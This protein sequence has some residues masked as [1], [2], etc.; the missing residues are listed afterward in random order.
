[1]GKDVIKLAIFNKTVFQPPQLISY[2][3]T[4]YYLQINPSGC[5]LYNEHSLSPLYQLQEPLLLIQGMAASTQQ[6]H[7]V[8]IKAN[9]DLCYTLINGSEKNQT[10]VLA[11]LDVRTTRYRRLLL[12]PLGKT[13]HI[14]YAY[15][16]QAIPDLWRIEHRFWNGKTWRSVNLGEVVHPRKPLYDIVLDRRG[17][18][19]LVM[20]T[21]LGRQ[22]VVLTN[23]FNGSFYLWGNTSQVFQIP[24]EVIDITSIITPDNI[25]HLFWLAKTPS[26]KFELGWAYQANVQDIAGNWLKAPAALQTLNG[27]IKGLGAIEV[28]GS[29]WLLVNAEAETLLFYKGDGWKQVLSN[30]PSHRHLRYI[31]KNSSSYYN[32]YWLEESHDSRTPAYHQHLG[33]NLIS[34]SAQTNRSPNIPPISSPPTFTQVPAYSQTNTYNQSP[35]TYP[36]SAARPLPQ[37]NPPINPQTID[38]SAYNTVQ[39]PV[40]MSISTSPV[41][42]QTPTENILPSTQLQQKPEL[43]GTQIQNPSDQNPSQIPGSLPNNVPDSNPPNQ[44]TIDLPQNEFASQ[45]LIDDSLLFA[46]TDYPDD[47]IPPTQEI[48]SITPPIFLP[49][50]I[51]QPVFAAQPSEESILEDNTDSSALPDSLPVFASA[52]VSS[53]EPEILFDNTENLQQVLSPIITNTLDPFIKT[54]VELE[55]QVKKIQEENDQISQKFHQQLSE[56]Q[57]KH[58][59]TL[60]RIENR[61]D[62]FDSQKDSSLRDFQLQLSELQLEHQSTLKNIENRL[63]QF[64]SQKDSSLRDFQ[65]QLSE[66]QLEHKTTLENIENRL[67]QFDTQKDSSLQEFQQQL[68][69]LQLEH[70]TTLE[71]IEYLNQIDSQKDSSL[72]KFEQQ[73]SELQLEHKTTLEKIEYLNQIDSQKDSSLQKF[74][75]QLSELQQKEQ[76]N[77]QKIEQLISSIQLDREEAQKHEKGFWERWFR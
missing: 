13:I 11:K 9:G 49:A 48:S 25:H 58:E 5:V 46:Y 23:R 50:N 21:F 69:E 24:Q 54:V 2:E 57:L 51:D 71:K 75:L 1:M 6:V 38:K 37:S 56:L 31:R 3:D 20:I 27:P 42:A 74:E 15:S 45:P 77:H 10:T 72:Q 4:Q 61:L 17:N 32:A 53:P 29:L 44:S 16:H 66:L 18:L 30:P 12:F 55:S 70:K 67:D 68:S 65:Q 33:L 43:P 36:P 35:R 28:N 26:A 8:M 7:L 47:L 63:N 62:Q 40:A 76:S 39:S 73:L 60:E 22:T 34:I 59:T 14:F 41:I 64:D 52:K 19:H